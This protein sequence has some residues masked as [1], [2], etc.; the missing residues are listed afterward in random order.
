MRL[1]AFLLVGCTAWAAGA[2]P[3]FA[4]DAAETATITA[5]TA[6][7]TARG[8]RTVGSAVSGGM[9]RVANSIRSGGSGRR[10][11]RSKGA[12]GGV[13]IGTGDPLEDSNAPVQELDSGASIRTSGGFRPSPRDRCESDCEQQIVKPESPES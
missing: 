11:E 5:G 9:G 1:A 10:S 6:A 13:V 2:L 7:P 3:A 4:Q 12:N 8:G